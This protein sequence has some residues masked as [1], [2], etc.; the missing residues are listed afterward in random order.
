MAPAVYT[1]EPSF[2]ARL[3]ALQ[4]AVEEGVEPLGD[5]GARVPLS[6]ILGGGLRLVDVLPRPLRSAAEAAQLGA[7]GF[8]RGGQVLTE[9]GRRAT[10]L[11]AA[12]ADTSELFCVDLLQHLAATGLLWPGEPVESIAL[13]AAEWLWRERYLAGQL[14]L[15]CL[16]LRTS[17]AGAEADEARARDGG[18]AGGGGDGWLLEALE[19]FLLAPPSGAPAG[20]PSSGTVAV[21]RLAEAL[22]STL[23]AG[24]GALGSLYAPPSPLLLPRDEPSA[25]AAGGAQP[26]AL[27]F[28]GAPAAPAAGA[29][30][31]FGGFGAAALPLAVADAPADGANTAR[32]RELSRTAR[33]ATALEAAA[34]AQ[35]LFWLAYSAAPLPAAADAAADDARVRVLGACARAL[36]SHIARG[37][38]PADPL[39]VL[40]AVPSSH[41]LMAAAVIG[42]GARAG[43]PRGTAAMESDDVDVAA[44]AVV[45][46]GVV[47]GEG[48]LA[49]GECLWLALCAP[50]LALRDDQLARPGGGGSGGGR[51]LREWAARELCDFDAWRRTCGSDAPAAS[52]ALMLALCD[53]AAAAPA[54]GAT[55]ADGGGGGYGALWGGGGAGAGAL[56]PLLALLRGGGGGGAPLAS[57]LGFAAGLAAP[58]RAR[59]RAGR[60]SEAQ[61][62]LLER[63]AA[64]AL[65]PAGVAP[66]WA[67]AP[68][69]DSL[70]ARLALPPAPFVDEALGALAHLLVAAEPR[71]WAALLADAA[72]AEADADAQGAHAR[73]VGRG[74]LVGLGGAGRE[75]TMPPAHLR[76]AELLELVAA[77]AF[78]SP[79][80][81]VRYWCGSSVQYRDKCENQY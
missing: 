6:Q 60:P 36:R 30:A 44:V 33:A 66:A 12:Y 61:A 1:F 41:P 53:P 40:R 80:T 67:C 5:D 54:D 15:E 77:A 32:E 43:G 46:C 26:A 13:V 68:L 3:R 79:G 62:G 11:L 56:P 27:G 42:G 18:A 39:S 55:A 64:T 22:A 59:A 7:A 65:A 52:V 45:G 16:K 71:A 14:L 78:G 20:A 37:G 57:G 75:A 24:G 9:T 2:E 74:A 47:L 72:R 25:G 8:A 69:A 50:L 70:C 28:G 34:C 63:A 29:L 81:C 19:A 21:G 58:C 10:L 23:D 51:A 35:A 48:A 73:T 17:L 38:Y 76:L 31:A 4:R 49:V